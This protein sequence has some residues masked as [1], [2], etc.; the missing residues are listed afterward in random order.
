MHYNNGARLYCELE[1][2]VTIR[3]SAALPLIFFCCGTVHADGVGVVVQAASDWVYHGASEVDGGD[4]L[5]LNVEWQINNLWFAG[6]EAHIADRQTPLRQRQRSIAAYVGR[7]AALSDSW[8][9][10]FALSHREFPGSSKEWDFTELHLS[11]T[12]D[13]GLQFVAD[14]SN[15]YYEHNTESLISELSYRR[16]LAD[17]FYGFALGGRA[18]FQEKHIP[19]YSYFTLGAGFS[20][21]AINAELSY[22]YNSE[23]DR[24][25]GGELLDSPEFVLQ[26]SY[27]LR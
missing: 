12:H 21:G 19:E 5:G 17:R 11:F 7:T 3:R 23:D 20:S 22:T 26:L 16:N 15:D 10:S 18:L 4:T 27:R 2:R 25:L 8:V 14:I 9:G 1:R 6:V 24:D 13:S